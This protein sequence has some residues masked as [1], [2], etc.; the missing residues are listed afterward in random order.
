MDQPKSQ[1]LETHGDRP[2]TNTN[3]DLKGVTETELKSSEKLRRLWLYLHKKTAIKPRPAIW[4]V[5]Q[6]SERIYSQQTKAV[7][8]VKRIVAS[9][10]SYIEKRQ[11]KLVNTKAGYDE[12]TGQ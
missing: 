11:D 1:D 4:A 8:N 3:P 5:K 10:T 12:V 6:A 7:E 9:E 2:V